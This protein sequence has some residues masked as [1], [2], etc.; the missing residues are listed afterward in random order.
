MQGV[1]LPA[2]T[3]CAAE[4]AGGEAF[5]HLLPPP[6]VANLP[7]GLMGGQR[8]VFS[9]AAVL[10]TDL[11]L[12]EVLQQPQGGLSAG[13]KGG[14]LEREGR[15]GGAEGVVTVSLSTPPYPLPPQKNQDMGLFLCIPAQS[16]IILSMT[17]LDRMH[18]L[19]FLCLCNQQHLF[20]KLSQTLI[21]DWEKSQH[22]NLKLFFFIFTTC[23]FKKQR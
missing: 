18:C 15:A 10:P 5:L 20:E 2:T 1:T 12:L 3:L 21:A 9:P 6:Q 22:K 4:V 14:F 8:E 16:G 19:H 13:R 23:S 7:L 11:M 17:D